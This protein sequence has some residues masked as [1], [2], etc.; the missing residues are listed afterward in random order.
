MSLL[1]DA[2]KK[3]ADDKKK[4][5]DGSAAH[6]EERDQDREIT[7]N[8]DDDDSL[9]L[10]LDL[11]TESKDDIRAS[12]PETV[13]ETDF[14][15]VDEKSIKTPVSEIKQ[16]V[17]KPL[18]D[19]DKPAAVSEDDSLEINKDESL[20]ATID[21]NDTAESPLDF[22][23]EQSTETEIDKAITHATISQENTS[24][25]NNNEAVA[26][27]SDS[28]SLLESP[29]SNPPDTNERTN[30]L[31]AEQALSALINK[32]NTYTRREQL[33]RTM[34]IALL[35][36]LLL[37]GS[38]IFFYI[39]VDTATQELFIA[40]NNSA[41]VNRNI[42]PE[43]VTIVATQA[44]S[45]KPL[46]A[47]VSQSVSA[48][49]TIPLKPVTKPR[50][51]AKPKT[52]SIVQTNK[53]DPINQ[54]LQDAYSSFINNDFER[55][56]SLYAQVNQQEPRNRDALLGQAAVAVKQQR[57]E[58]ARQKYQTLLQL[59][60]KDSLATAGISSIENKI[61]PQLNISQ[62]K[63]MLK[64]QPDSAH[65]YFAL[66]SL[67]AAKANWPE[68][69]S[70]YFSAWSADSSNADYA[71]NLA[72]SLDHI[73]KPQQ[74]L[75]FYSMSLKLKQASRGN[76]SEQATLHRIKRLQERNR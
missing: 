41:P 72:V 39:K 47:P 35:V 17:T 73:N 68:A 34:A 30:K 21:H 48:E 54:L 76:F 15:A 62:L 56:Q 1:L 6:I 23:E 14:P 13:A 8:P 40:Q 2:L 11:Q 43:P 74:A 18:A 10:E 33:K 60:P 5:L 59:N 24:E 19:A 55:S 38:A 32:S 52:F 9:E 3:A 4:N 49:K 63:F 46:K 16:P 58:Y 70:A 57:Y 51:A 7:N 28:S 44:P 29:A 61:D 27:S 26:D 45:N 25:E 20:N 42:T 65:L 22:S 64:E 53:A 69:Q 75:Q 36:T 50:P 66:G 12:G 37:I 31:A 71:Y 67:Y